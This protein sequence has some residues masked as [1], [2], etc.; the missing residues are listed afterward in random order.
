MQIWVKTLAARKMPLDVDESTTILDVK[1]ELNEKEGIDV[2]QIRLIFQ[3]KMT[4]DTSTLGAL[5]VKAGEQLHMVLA[6][7]G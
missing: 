5:G 3:G 4:A 1:K 7:R 6:L 2:A